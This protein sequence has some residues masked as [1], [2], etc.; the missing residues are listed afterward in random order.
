MVNATAAALYKSA[1]PKLRAWSTVEPYIV[2][3]PCLFKGYCEKRCPQKK[4]AGKI[5]PS[6]SCM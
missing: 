6:H 5:R 4:K 3:R 1:I 2:I